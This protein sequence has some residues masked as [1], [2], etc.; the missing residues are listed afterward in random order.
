MKNPTAKP[1]ANNTQYPTMRTL[2]MRMKPQTP[3]N[4]DQ[5]AGGGEFVVDRPKAENTVTGTMPDGLI[6]QPQEE[7]YIYIYTC[8]AKSQA[9]AL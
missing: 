4:P 3:E 9:Q 7:R 2:A 1:K 5:P 6:Y 8:T